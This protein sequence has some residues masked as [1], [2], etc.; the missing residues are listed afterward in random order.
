MSLPI[1][2]SLVG[3]SVY[4]VSEK[5]GRKSLRKALF[6]AF[7][8][9]AA[10]IDY[11]PG[12]LV[13]KSHLF[14]HSVTHSIAAALIFGLVAG[15]LTSTFKKR[16]FLKWFFLSSAIYLSHPLLDLLSPSQIPLFWPFESSGII[17][18]I[19]TFWSSPLDCHSIAD[20]ACSLWN[21]S[22]IKRF[23]REISILGLALGL[24]AF[25]WM[26]RFCFKSFKRPAI[27]IR[28]KTMRLEIRSPLLPT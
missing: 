6:T 23:W 9:T 20:F 12:V 8:A 18:Q 27:S 5:T 1:V 22:C 25:R 15:L 7:A 14:H 10:D 24:G 17:G 3:Y 4:R 26:L 19:Q 11:L 21:P 28:P 16:S 13:G 2:H